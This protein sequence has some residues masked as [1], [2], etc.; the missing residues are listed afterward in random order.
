MIPFFLGQE[1]RPKVL[2]SNLKI[3][4]EDTSYVSRIQKLQ[5]P[6]NK[7]EDNL[8]LGGMG[9]HDL[10]H[11]TGKLTYGFSQKYKNYVSTEIA[12]EKNVPEDSKSVSIVDDKGESSLAFRKR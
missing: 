6:S 4:D 2:T 12:P 9:N 7:Y 5:F 1:K 8:N 3:T 10:S 11:V